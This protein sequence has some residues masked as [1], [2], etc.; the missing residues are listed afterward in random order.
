[1]TWEFIIS[2]DDQEIV[3]QVRNDR[4]PYWP[5]PAM[6]QWFKDS[7]I[8]EWYVEPDHKPIHSLLSTRPGIKGLIFCLKNPKDAAL[9]KLTWMNAQQRKP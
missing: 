2:K 1:M 3:E 9:F 5:S 4:F 8:H 6:C 7:N